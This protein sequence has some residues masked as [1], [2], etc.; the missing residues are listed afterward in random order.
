MNRHERENYSWQIVQNM[1]ER[2]ISSAFKLRPLETKNRTPKMPSKKRLKRIIK[3]VI[4]NEIRKRP[5]IY[6]TPR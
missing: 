4:Q 3:E 6:D 5:S 1:I 2:D